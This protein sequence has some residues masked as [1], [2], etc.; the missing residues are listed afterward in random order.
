M[1]LHK[2]RKKVQ[3][4]PTL[5]YR[6]TPLIYIIQYISIFQ[7]Y[8]SH[9]LIILYTISGIFQAYPSHILY[10][11]SG[12]LLAYPSHIKYIRHIT[13]LPLSYTLYQAYYRPAP[14]IYSISGIDRRPAPLIDTISGILQQGGSILGIKKRQVVCG[15]PR[16]KMNIKNI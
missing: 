10:T 8:P 15:S 4:R 16:C 13:G 2:I 7:A 1:T 12:I 11:I 3:N 6:P 9:I 14:L 5:F